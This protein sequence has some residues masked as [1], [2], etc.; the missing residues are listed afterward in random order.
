MLLFKRA[1]ARAQ[2]ANHFGDRPAIAAREWTL[3]EASRTTLASDRNFRQESRLL[4]LYKT[5]MT[6]KQTELQTISKILTDRWEQIGAKL[7]DLAREFPEERYEAAP[8]AGVRTFGGVLRHV[9]FWNQYAAD[10]ASGKRAGDSAN[11][12]P[13]ASYASKAQVIAALIKSSHD[14]LAALR[15]NAGGLGPDKAALAESFIEHMCEH[16]GQLVVYAR[17]A[18][19]TPPVSRT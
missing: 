18:G 6:A 4:P 17:W 3:V 2:R 1:V 10:T 19:V 13:R 8:V 9:A 11:E 5:N 14:A 16:Y 7:A 12:L 15:E